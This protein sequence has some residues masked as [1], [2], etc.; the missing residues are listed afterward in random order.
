MISYIDILEKIE[1]IN[2]NSKKKIQIK[3]LT[4]F[5]EFKL[6][7][8]TEYFLNEKKIY[9][10]T[11][12]SNYDQILQQLKNYKPKQ[13]E[14]LLLFNEINQYENINLPE[15][16]KLILLQL[17]ILNKIKI[18][19]PSLEIIFFNLP[20]IFRKFSNLK[21]NIKEVK[22]ISNLN[23]TLIKEAKNNIHIFDYNK[24]VNNIGYE[25]I[26]DF[27]NYYI[28][29]SLLTDNANY[30]IAKEL[31][32]LIYS[33]KN[34][35][36]K[37]LVLDLD[38]TLWG[39]ILG[40]DGIKNIK[41]SNDYVGE[42]FIS[43]QKYIKTLSNNGV[44]LALCSKNNLKDVEECFKER[45]DLFLKFKDFSF[46]KINWEPKYKNI[47]EISK[48]MNI[49]KDSIVFFDDSKFERDQMKKFNPEINVIEVPDDPHNYINALEDSAYF[50]S[51]KDLTS[52]DLKKKKQYEMI[53]KA[54]SLKDNFS[55][56][57]IDEYLKNL[58][59]KIFLSNVN[60]KNFDRSVQMLN[61]IN[62]FNL[63]TKRYSASEFKNYLKNNKN[64]TL[65]LRVID[66][67]GDHGN[68]GL[69]TCII[70]G[71][72]LIIDNFVLSCRILGRKIENLVL[73]EI[74]TFAK[75]K[76]IEKII[77]VYK[78][79]MKNSQCK[80]FYIKNNFEKEKKNKFLFNIKKN[81]INFKPLA[82]I[83][84]ENK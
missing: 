68:V 69:V 58:K 3:Y 55:D 13:N 62:Q 49:G 30:I 23:H 39:G 12:K 84:Y 15:L 34:V 50:Y 75:Q 64:Y 53:G 70:K 22:F 77:G 40:E 83:I 5:N 52:E 9:S 20:F 82:R 21:K 10:K 1:N 76:K 67:F 24:I 26:Y 57:D 36:K 29:K 4:N 7:A 35:K 78:K 27:R 73:R 6:H 33:I 79:S 2:I 28:S 41:L 37:C 61:K 19:F 60:N 31:S 14:I 74:E 16:K 59:M 17:N 71:K 43:F 54:K 47:N 81:K 56:D 42:F 18:K 8:Y 46:K 51:N 48:E 45:K 72:N 32:K 66:K 38:N 25:N 63:T 44:I 11:L 65:V 80:D